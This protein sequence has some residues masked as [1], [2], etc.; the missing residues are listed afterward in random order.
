MPDVD[1]KFRDKSQLS[2]LAG[3]IVSVV[4]F[5]DKSERLVVGGYVKRAGFQDV[6]EVF[7][8]EK[9]GQQFSSECAVLY[10]V[11]GGFIF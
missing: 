11:S 3:R 6:P 1:C 2:D 9:K 8:T 5:K 4:A 7:Y 10:L